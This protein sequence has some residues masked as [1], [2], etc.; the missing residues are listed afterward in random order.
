MAV[1][2]QLPT[3][4]QIVQDNKLPTPAFV[5]Y[6]QSL[7]KEADKGATDLTAIQKELDDTQTGAGLNTGGNYVAPTGTN[8]LDS[9]TSLFN[10]DLY[11]DAAISSSTKELVTTVTTNT[12]LSAQNQTI[13][14]DATSADIDI[15]LPDPALTFSSN[16][17]FR[18]TITRKDT[19]S[20]KVTIIPFD[21][22][23]ILDEE[24]QDL[25]NSEVIN[26]ITDG[27]NWYYSA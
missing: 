15:T 7:Q 25:L 3:N 19:T 4:I 11:L 12:E 14:V 21:A 2:E 17:S 5:F 9:A 18:I 1:S 6:L 8:Y 10:A 24:S 23:L 27:T 20:N 26:L 13:L 22:E 16:R